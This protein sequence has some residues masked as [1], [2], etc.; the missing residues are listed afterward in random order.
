MDKAPAEPRPAEL[1]EYSRHGVIRVAELERLGIS[2]YTSYRRCGPGGPWQWVLPG[3]V[4]LDRVPLTHRQRLEAALLHGRGGA[5]VT[6][7]AACRLYGL[8]EPPIGDQVHLLIPAGRQ[9]RS[10]GHVHIERTRHFPPAQTREGLPVAP[11]ERAVLDCVRRIR[12]L[13][14]VR[15]LLI[16]AVQRGGCRPSDLRAEL[17]TGSQRGTAVPR[18]VLN[19]IGL[20]V[21]SVAE[22]RTERLWRAAGLPAPM[23]NVEVYDS[24]GEFIA[25]PDLW[26]DEVALAWEI[27]SVEFHFKAKDYAR[28]VRR[29][30]RYSRAGIAVVQTLPAQ[31]RDHPDAVVSDLSA[32]FRAAAAR[33]RPNVTCQPRAA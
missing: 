10:A 16:E 32:A 20:G 15:A 7:A 21:R 29:N 33:N 28:T 25:V 12:L 30:T 11:L 26:W 27:D 9:I 24:A 23:R 14:P 13:N 18:R 2:S 1:R 19:E 8:R 22:A 17:D 3:I 31:L 5:L 4:S 6:G